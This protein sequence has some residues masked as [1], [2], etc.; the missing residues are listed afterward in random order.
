MGNSISSYSQ[1]QY[2][3]QEDTS[4]EIKEET[5]TDSIDYIATYYI[6]T[7]DFQSLRKLYEK[8]YCQELVV[9]TSDIINKYFNDLEVNEIADRIEAGSNTQSKEKIIYFKKSDVEL[10]NV[11]NGEKKQIICNQ[12]A[13]FYVK[14]A[15]LFSTIVTTINPEYTYKDTNGNIV[16]RSLSEKDTIPKDV[17]VF[18]SKLNLCDK[19]IDGLKGKTFSDDFSEDPEKDVS[20]H[21]DVCEINLSDSKETP[22]SLEDVPGIPE[23]MELYYDGD[24][25]FTTGKF[26]TMTD[27]T[28]QQFLN[29]LKRFYT[30]F[31]DNSELPQ[32]I[33]KFSDIKLRDYSK[34]PFC[35]NKD[36][37]EKTFTGKYKDKLFSDY[38][39]NLK[40]M[41]Q[42]VNDKQKLLL[43][44]LNKIF[45]YVEDPVTKENKIRINPDLNEETLQ[46]IIVETR[47]A[48]VELYLKCEVDFTEG[49]KLYEAIIEAQIL[50]TSQKQIETL[51]SE[52]EKLLS[53]ETSSN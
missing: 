34:K 12:I 16:K 46:D 4:K 3:G 37:S 14:I 5:L 38:A 50:E 51:E 41:I 31:T 39:S 28:K 36:I 15:H 33:S 47:N 20:V 23:L 13:K 2:G 1:F 22:I 35:S 43:G 25:D 44:I 11:P 29:D 8:E 45:V 49:V 30:T 42:S 53:S 7:M 32:E 6:L 52:K 27:T 17:E 40:N 48:V 24:Y 26:T 18:V 19:K 21:P 10:M 9:L